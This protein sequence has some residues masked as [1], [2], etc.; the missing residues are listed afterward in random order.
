[1]C[2]KCVDILIEHSNTKTIMDAGNEWSAIPLNNDELQKC[3][4]GV[5][6]SNCFQFT[7]NNNGN[8]LI[9]GRVCILNKCLEIFKNNEQVLDITQFITCEACNKKLC[10]DSLNSHN[11]SKKHLDNIER[12]NKEKEE[13]QKLKLLKSQ[14]RQ[15][16]NCNNYKIPIHKDK[17]YV[18]CMDCFKN[19]VLKNKQCPQ[20][21][22]SITTKQFDKY[23]KCFDCCTK[24]KKPFK[25]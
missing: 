4:C 14:Y 9:I 25:F 16:N 22:I 20:C 1:M 2:K 10:Y 18:L 13:K 6:S 17:K 24:Y 23:K 12:L 3:I 19:C 15:C 7:N 8:I 11:K 5:K 21:N